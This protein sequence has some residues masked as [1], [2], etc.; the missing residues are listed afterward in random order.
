MVSDQAA[1]FQS[2]EDR[3]LDHGQEAYIVSVHLLKT[4]MAIRSLAAAPEAGDGADLAVA[5]LNR[6]LN[7]PIRRRMVRRTARQALRFVAVDI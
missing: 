1:F 3:L 4:T 2:V 7:S 6:M 5:A